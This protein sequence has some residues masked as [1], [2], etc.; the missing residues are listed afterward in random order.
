MNIVIFEDGNYGNFLPLSLT[1]PVWDLR[2]GCFSLRERWERLAESRGIAARFMYE[3]RE[4]L[5][6]LC[7][8]AAP[9]LTVNDHAA[10]AKAGGALFVNAA[11]IADARVFDIG[12]NSAL[13]A[14]ETVLAARLDAAAAAG[15]TGPA[16][17]A[18]ASLPGLKK[19]RDD[20]FAVY[21]YLW[22][23]VDGCGDAMRRDYGL[24]ARERSAAAPEGVTIL[25]D[26]AQV[27][28]GK[29]ARIDPFVCIDATGGSVV[30]LEGTTVHS[31]T[32]IEGPCFIGRDCVIL[33]AKLRGGTS[34][35]N[36]CRIGGEVEASVFQGRSNKYHDGF[37]G[38]SYVGEWVNLGALTTN[39][40]LK[41]NYS[42]VR[43]SPGGK[44]ISTGRLKIGCYIGDHTRTGIGT[45]INT[46]SVIGPGCMLV[47]DGT[48]A[49][50]HMPPFAWFIGGQLTEGESFESFIATCETVM[51]R[52]GITTGAG[53]KGLLA[54]LYEST[55]DA[56]RTES[57][58]WKDRR[59]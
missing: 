48:M 44:R 40:D 12:E 25:G 15:L 20:S 30:I 29:G 26:G 17:A 28:I 58:E 3:T 5:A 49:P 55:K 23:L 53:L 36:G 21:G 42:A 13:V 9:E 7:A 27:Y 34:I 47:Q 22:D 38:H 54:R 10:R 56:R 43:V 52:R 2:T 11:L 31:F 59:K 33:G 6:P 1:R 4:E 50:R 39:S 19:L 14:G 57:E 51:S 32:R 18:L 16:R 46:G 45:L 41:N 8:E 24:I 35:G 37:I